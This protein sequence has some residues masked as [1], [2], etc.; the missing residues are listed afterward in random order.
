MLLPVLVVGPQDLVVKLLGSC[1]DSE[2]E[3]VSVQGEDPPG[4]EGTFSAN[5]RPLSAP[6]KGTT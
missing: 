6:A 1:N 4:C 3:V 5:S 2:M